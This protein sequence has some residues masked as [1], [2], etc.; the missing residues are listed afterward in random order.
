MVRTRALFPAFLL[1]L[2]GGWCGTLFWGAS[3][4]AGATSALVLLGAL[5]VAA[6][7][8]RDPLRLGEIA[9]ALPPA[10]WVWCLACAELSPV[11]RAGRVGLLLLPAF[12]ALPAV[13]ARC[14]RDE[15]ARRVGARALAL[16]V[17]AIAAWAI[18]D[19]QALGAP[20]PAMPLGHH[21]LLAA[22][23]VALLPAAALPGGEPGRWRYAGWGAAAVALAAILASRSLAG[24]A[25]VVTEA[26]FFWVGGSRRAPSRV[27][28]LPAVAAAVVI[29]LALVGGIVTPRFRGL[30]SGEDS[31]LRA[32]S[33]YW[34]AGWR[35]FLA[36]PLSGW[37]P[38]STAWTLSPFLERIPGVNPP[39]EVVTELHDLPLALAYEL[40][41]PGLLLGV[42]L[43]LAFLRR[44]WAE[45]TE[46][47]DPAWTLAG[48]AGIAGL[49][50]A[51]LGSAAL[52]VTALPCAAAVVAGVALAGTQVPEDSERH[53]GRLVILVY[54][55][56]A[57]AVLTPILWAQ[58]DYGRAL[59][60][61]RAGDARGARAALDRAAA[62][63]P[64]FPLYPLRAALLASADPA[65]YAA[66]ADLAHRAAGEAVSLPLA[67][68]VAGIL[69]HSAA[70]PWAG[71]ALARAES[72]DPMSPFPP[73][74]RL[75]GETDARRAA[76]LGARALL[77]EPRL[78]LSC[79]W[80]TRRPLLA[81]TLE[82]VRVWPGV[83]AGWKE[84]L[85]A[86]VASARAVPPA[87]RVRLAL[88]LDG[89]AA[90]SV[91][92]LAFRRSPWPLRWALVTLCREAAGP[93]LPPALTLPGA[94]AGPLR[95]SLNLWRSS[96]AH[97]S[98]NPW[99]RG[100]SPQRLWKNLWRNALGTERGGGRKRLFCELP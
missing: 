46:G 28:R 9:V 62:L 66:A 96:P 8:W 83:D 19:W 64:R 61:V 100:G 73:F 45:R 23:L 74:Y 5:V 71:A 25:A 56:A 24:G 42:A 38:G 12:L 99:A 26:V 70:L 75:L 40:G 29:A 87:E 90:T 20:R 32:R 14:L 53:G 51:A 78:A 77:A 89:D 2:F 15:T 10:L 84:G 76:E 3:A 69:G 35:G 97:P 86:E 33:T 95:N 7:S 50:V 37:G 92:L 81:R 17:L 48:C 54:A 43:P 34:Q 4:A 18:V 22:F 67:W 93:A 82:E 49:A 94:S 98:R 27:R 30:I 57:L 13:V 58:R 44:R 41:V 60:L 85:L 79:A 55:L 68:E 36:R 31:S 11:P 88:V 47:P 65:S 80:E 91:S 1:L 59:G 39:G 16:V 21:N 63:D 6:P 72:L 52:S